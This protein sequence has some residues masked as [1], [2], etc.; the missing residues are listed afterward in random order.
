MINYNYLNNYLYK[1][2]QNFSNLIPELSIAFITPTNFMIRERFFYDITANLMI[3][4]AISL[5]IKKNFKP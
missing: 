3:T 4:L 1:P 2:I 5:I